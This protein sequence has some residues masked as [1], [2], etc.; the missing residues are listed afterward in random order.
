MPDITVHHLETSRSTRILWFLEE[1]EVDY[2]IVRHQR[3]DKGRATASLE[4]VHPL[5]KAPAVV[6]DSQVLVESGAILETVAERL[7]EGRLGVDRDHEDFQQYRFFLHYAEGS[8]MTPLLVKLL[9][10]RVRAAPVPFFVRPIARGIA[11][12][13]DEAYTT[14]ELKR[15]A[16]FLD[17][18]LEGREWFCAGRPTAA[19]I[20]LAY[21]IFALIQRGGADQPRLKAWVERVQARPAWQRALDKGGPLFPGDA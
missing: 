16:A 15:H 19:D 9:M 6:L 1:L 17:S 10:N 5:G 4:Q 18:A 12:K 21:P 14:G 8:V 20:Q 3:D 11:D 7:G 2:E 13:L